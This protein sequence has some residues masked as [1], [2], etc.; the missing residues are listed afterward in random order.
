MIE[1]GKNPVHIQNISNQYKSIQ[2]ENVTRM[3][4]LAS[5]YVNGVAG[6]PHVRGSSTG[7]PSSKL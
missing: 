3:S 5:I 2:H 4:L 1:S 6:V 7:G